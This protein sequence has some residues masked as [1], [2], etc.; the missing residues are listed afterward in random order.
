MKVQS[1]AEQSIEHMSQAVKSSCTAD[2]IVQ[3]A[4]FKSH[5]CQGH[6]ER[7]ARL[8]K[9]KYREYRALLFDV[10]ERT[11]VEIDP[12][13][14][15]SAWMLRHSVWLL[16]RYQPHRGE[17]HHSNVSLEVLTDL[18][19]SHCS[20]W[21]SVLCHRIENLEEFSCLR[22]EYHEHSDQC[23]LVAQKSCKRY[24]VSRKTRLVVATSSSSAQLLRVTSL[25]VTTR[26]SKKDG[27]RRQDAGHERQHMETNIWYDVKH[28]DTNIV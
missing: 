21:L 19:L 4:P 8:V 24:C 3:R 22:K 20:R 6:V 9:N 14:A 12:I 26:K 17:Q 15:A 18:R 13:S 1:D 7:V 27:R 16:N 2:L 10:Q 11:R 23:G 5:T 25:M 28:V